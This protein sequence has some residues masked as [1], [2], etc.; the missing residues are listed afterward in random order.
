MQEVQAP[1]QIQSNYSTLLAPLQLPIAAVCEGVSQVSPLPPQIPE[2][3]PNVPVATFFG[4]TA[5][6]Q[7]CK[8]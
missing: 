3:S 1:D 5:Q 4:S 2:V 7:R 8:I 6:Q